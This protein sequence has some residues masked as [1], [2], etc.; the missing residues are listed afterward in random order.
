M[1][2]VSEWAVRRPVYALLTWIGIMIAVGVLGTT[3]G[4]NYNDD[5]KLPDTESTTAQN[6]LENLSGS[7]GA[8]GGV[9]GQIVWRAETG[10]AIESAAGTD[11]KALLTKISTM[12]GVECVQTPFGDPLG[13]GCPAPP[14]DQGSDEGTDQSN[15]DQ[16]PAAQGAQAHFGQSG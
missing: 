11:M 14:A 6:L 8:G 16:S 9:Y 10:K 12:R 1:G 2:R 3:I 7:A 15:D 5:F 13:S 4:G